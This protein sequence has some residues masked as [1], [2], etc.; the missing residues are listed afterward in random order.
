MPQF[1]NLSEIRALIPIDMHYRQQKS[2]PLHSASSYYYVRV[3]H[4]DA[5]TSQASK[6]VRASQGALFDIFKRMKAFLM[7]GDLYWSGTGSKSGGYSHENKGRK[8]LNII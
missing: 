3:A 1:V 5:I 2:S 4:R 7:T 8:M 6:N